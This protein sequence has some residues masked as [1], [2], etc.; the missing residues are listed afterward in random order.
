MSPEQAAG[1]PALD[2]RSD[3]YSLACVLY[4]MLAGKPPFTGPTAESV[5]H[6]HLAVP[7]APVRTVR[8]T[9]PPAVERALE[10]ALAKTP[11][12]RF[13]TANDLAT[14]IDPADVRAASEGR[15]RRWRPWAL[16]AGA[17]S[18]GAIG[19]AYALFSRSPSAGAAGSSN[20]VAVLYFDN[21]SR[22]S[23]DAY[24]ADGLTEEITARLSRVQRLA[25]KSRNAVRRYLGQVTD[26]PESLGNALRV[27]YLVSG[28]VRRA[29]N[30]VRVGVE[31]TR[32]ATGLRTWGDE[33]ERADT[34]L[35]AIEA[36][37]GQAVTECER[38]MAGGW[39]PPTWGDGL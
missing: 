15:S 36:A 5:L 4:E 20:T 28:S 8:P 13:A 25:V 27:S 21:L 33:Y 2:G 19:I 17:A 6:Q 10:R 1:E 16:I 35:F 31:L 34:N 29:G 30:R 32:G 9:A 24:L 18:L 37:V 22:D 7:A 39:I 38:A 26:D 3:L 11:A 12:D 23:T 14:A